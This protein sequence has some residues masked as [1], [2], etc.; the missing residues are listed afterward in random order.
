MNGGKD[1]RPKGHFQYEYGRDILA[2]GNL[3]SLRIEDMKSHLA[4]VIEKLP[5]DN[6]LRTYFEY[7]LTLC[8]DYLKLR[9][10]DAVTKNIYN[11]FV[12]S[13]GI[14]MNSFLLS[15]GMIFPSNSLLRTGN[16]N[17]FQATSFQTD[18]LNEIKSYFD[19]HDEALKRVVEEHK[20]MLASIIKEQEEMLKI[21]EKQKQVALEGAAKFLEAMFGNAGGEWAKVLGIGGMFGMGDMGDLRMTRELAEG[22][23][24]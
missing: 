10:L 23:R 16:G 22:A 6:P 1:V 5:A 9:E 21:A 24:K 17:F 7:L 15:G 19:E 18:N 8:N 13:E 2:I 4:A 20:K 12:E 14:L 3:G 11:L